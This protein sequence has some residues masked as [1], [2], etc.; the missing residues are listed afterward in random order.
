MAKGLFESIFGFLQSSPEPRIL[1]RPRPAET[2]RTNPFEGE[3]K[4]RPLQSYA[5]GRYRTVCVRLCDG[6]FFPISNTSSRRDF[7]SDA[8]QCRS[9]C[10]GNTRLFY[11]SPNNPS[12]KLAR[13]QRGLAYTDLKTAFLYRKKYSKSCSCRPAPWSVSERMRHKGYLP[14]AE[15]K[16]ASA[17]PMLAGRPQIV[18]REAGTFAPAPVALPFPPAPR[19]ARRHISERRRPQRPH[20]RPIKESG[21]G[22]ASGLPKAKYRHNWTTE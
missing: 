15:Q 2:A 11:M 17:T 14:G 9:S 18:D 19:A 8:Q 13:D 3:L 4:R 16:I 21:W 10:Q 20:R 7:Y 1:V 22:L 6:Y 12:I 5:K